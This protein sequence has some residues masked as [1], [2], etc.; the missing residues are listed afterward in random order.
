[1]S[2]NKWTGPLERTAKEQPASAWKQNGEDQHAFLTH[3]PEGC[4]TAHRFAAVKWKEDLFERYGFIACD[5]QQT[6]AGL[7]GER[8]RLKGGKEQLFNEVLNGMDLHRPPCSALRANEI[9]HP[10]NPPLTKSKSNRNDWGWEG[11]PYL[12]LTRVRN[13]DSHC[14]TDE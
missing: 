12:I 4:A 6:D 5:Q 13:T 3:Q 11:V 10:K 7:T 1:M 14:S 9:S 8:H 2:Y